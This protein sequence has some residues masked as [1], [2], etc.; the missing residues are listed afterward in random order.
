MADS[1]SFEEALTPKE[2]KSEAK[3][4]PTGFSFE[5]AAKPVERPT[6]GFSFEDAALKPDELGRYIA[7]SEERGRKPEDVGFLE[8]IPAAAKRGIESL[9]DVASGLGLA[10]TA[11][12]GTEE[13][14]RA[15]MQAIKADQNK[16]EEKPGMTVADFERIYKEKG[17]LEAAK[18]APKYIVEQFLQSAPQMAGP[19]AAGAVATPFLTPVGGALVGMGAYGIQQFGNFLVR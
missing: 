10:K 19:L 14:T 15:K 13:E 6:G 11:L 12:T 3:Q 17:F 1:F 7:R 8:S 5:E 4:K 18:E 16:P 2:E 9:G